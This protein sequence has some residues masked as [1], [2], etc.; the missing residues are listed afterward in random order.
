MTAL[1]FIASASSPRLPAGPTE[2]VPVAVYQF[3]ARLGPAS[4]ILPAR[5]VKS[6]AWLSLR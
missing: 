4:R 3:I 2:P 1:P 5:Q 6:Q